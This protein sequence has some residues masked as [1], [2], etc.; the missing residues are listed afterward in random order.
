MKPIER[1]WHYFLVDPFTWLFYY[2]CQPT[3]FPR[4]FE[5]EDFAKR[6]IPM[7][8]LAMPIFIV[9]YTLVFFSNWWAIILGTLGGVIWGTVGGIKWGIV[10]GIGLSVGLSIGLG[11]NGFTFA[12]LG[13]ILVGLGGGLGIGLGIIGSILKDSTKRILRGINWGVL[14]VLNEFANCVF[15]GF[16]GGFFGMIGG[17]L[18]E[19]WLRDE[20]RSVTGMVELC[21]IVGVV[22]G[23]TL[24]DSKKSNTGNTSEISLKRFV[25]RTIRY[26]AWSLVGGCIGSITGIIFWRLLEGNL[27][28]YLNTLAHNWAISTIKNSS[29]NSNN[30]FEIQYFFDLGII[31]GSTVG[32]TIGIALGIVKSLLSNPRY[33]VG[34]SIKQGLDK[35]LDRGREESIELGIGWG[36]LV[37]LVSVVTFNHWASIVNGIGAGVLFS[38]YYLIGYYRLPLYLVSSISTLRARENSKRNPSGVYRYLHRC[39]L[40]WNECLNLPLPFLQNILL[41]AVGQNI[42]QVL[43]E[44]AFIAAERPHQIP[45]ARMSLIEIIIQDL[46]KRKTLRDIAEASQQLA[47]FLQHGKGVLDPLW[48]AQFTYLHN[49]SLDALRCRT[50]L[51][52]QARYEAVTNMIANLEK[53][54][55][56]IEEDSIKKGVTKKDAAKK[57]SSKHLSHED[58]LKLRLSEKVNKWLGTVQGELDKLNQEPE[59]TDQINNPYIVGPVIDQLGTSLFVGRRE[60]AQQLEQALRRGSQRPTFFLNGERRMGKSSTLKQLPYLVDARYFLPIFY[61]LQA[62]EMSSSIAAFLGTVAEK[63]WKVVSN[64]IQLEDLE[65]RNLLEASRKNESEVY[66]VFDEWLKNVEQLLEQKD[67]TLLLTFDEFEH[68]EKVGQAKNLDLH[69]LLN[70]FRSVIQNRPRIALLFSGGRSIGEMSTETGINWAS[71]FVNV[72]TLR[73]SFLRETEARQLITRPLFEYSFEQIFDE[74]VVDEIIRVTGCHPFLVQAI[75]SAII[76]NLN[77]DKRDQA[78]V[79]DVIL[80]VNQVL[81]NWEAYFQDLWDRT[82]QNQRS[83]LFAISNLGKGEL[84][85]IAEQS[86]LDVRVIRRT[87]ET[88]RKRDLVLQEDGIYRIAAPIFIQWIERNY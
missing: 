86:N 26:V 46:E 11:E 82:N 10:G 45:A 42:D 2:F 69:L 74:R 28:Q 75:C 61:D 76:D 72:Q 33:K 51:R 18:I 25:R 32:V 17:V 78:M 73:V 37:T 85:K 81:E 79:Q 40:Y 52:W 29:S 30:D 59:K 12:N 35:H 43:E 60:L 56:A 87:L 41:I 23:C 16:V 47:R 31:L 6:I 54:T 68:L 83:C 3:N 20:T 66:F 80:A 65:R 67:W 36:V 13:N 53:I 39:A 70:W 5:T 27:Y 63:I 62:P 77:A 57:D 64:E 44:I 15:V 7:L 14:G 49:V 34:R 58:K 48:E 38:V 21:A 19:L 1:T 4:E 9:S 71:Y 55:Q 8:R 84:Q 24:V 50:S 88:L 22:T